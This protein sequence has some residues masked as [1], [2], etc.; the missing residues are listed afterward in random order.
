MDSHAVIWEELKFFVNTLKG[1]HVS[2]NLELSEK[3]FCV[4]TRTYSENWVYFP[5]G[6]INPEAVNMAVNFFR[7]RDE[8]FMWPVYSGGR[9]LL[10]GAG[11]I[12]AGDLAA[13]ML[14]PERVSISDY[15][16]DVKIFRS[17]DP[18]EW[19]I[20]SWLGFGGSDEDFP[21][22]Y[23][24][25]VKALSEAGERISLYSAKYDGENAGVFALTNECEVMG[26]YYFAV[27]PDFRRKGIARAMMSEICRYALSSEVRSP[28]RIVLQS[29]PMGHE[30]YSNFGFTDLFKIPVY[31]TESDI[32]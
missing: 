17:D 24:V 8:E 27:V 12:Y 11:L 26:V 9:E 25:F 1:L 32:F 28:K 29:T 10:E 30:F 5:E 31:S 13:M 22:N 23:R 15:R 20:T 14:K 19:A 21:E 7:E 16:P 4:S 6:I 18:E 2:I 3:T